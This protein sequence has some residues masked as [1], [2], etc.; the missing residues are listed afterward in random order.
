MPWQTVPG[1]IFRML[2]K[3]SEGRTSFMIIFLFLDTRMRS[4]NSLMIIPNILYDYDDAVWFAEWN[5][6]LYTFSFC[7][8]ML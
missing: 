1:Q 4:E 6:E 3:N 7:S 5:F 2:F 8:E